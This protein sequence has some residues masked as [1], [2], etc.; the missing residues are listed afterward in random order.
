MNLEPGKTGTSSARIYKWGVTQVQSMVF[1]T[2]KVKVIKQVMLEGG[3]WRE[4]L[5][6]ECPKPMCRL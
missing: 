3:N 2:G 6:L 4:K 1:D 5:K